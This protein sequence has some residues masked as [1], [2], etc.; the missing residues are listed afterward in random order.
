MGF[1]DR[2]HLTHSDSDLVV[3]LPAAGA[4]AQVK[5][6]KPLGVVQSTDKVGTPATEN[7]K[8]FRTAKS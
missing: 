1:L 3:T 4:K 5:L 8:L 2:G 6:I 7:Q